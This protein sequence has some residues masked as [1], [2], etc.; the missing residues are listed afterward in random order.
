M[1]FFPAFLLLLNFDSPQ[2]LDT[3]CLVCARRMIVAFVGIGFGDAKSEER[4]RK[5]LEAVFERG[6]IG[7]FW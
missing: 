4:E 5:Q 1:E 7:D 3:L 6:T 2:S